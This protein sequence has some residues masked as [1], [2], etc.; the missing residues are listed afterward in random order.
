MPN[1]DSQDFTR[2]LNLSKAHQKMFTRLQASPT[3]QLKLPH[4]ASM[5]IPPVQLVQVGQVAWHAAW[6]PVPGGSPP[7]VP[8]HLRRWHSS[9]KEAEAH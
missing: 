3:A 5:Q 9:S 7:P 6:Q 2:R 1:C 8:P 4:G